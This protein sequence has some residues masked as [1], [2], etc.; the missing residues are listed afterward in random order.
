MQNRYIVY[1][2]MACVFIMMIAMACCDS[3]R[4]KSPT[5]YIFLSIFTGLFSVMVGYSAAVS[6]PDAVS[7]ILNYI[8]NNFLLI[9]YFLI[10]FS[11]H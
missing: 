7:I 6:D 11:S 2:I 3:L 8:I 5:N 10:I 1:I 9:F 4:R